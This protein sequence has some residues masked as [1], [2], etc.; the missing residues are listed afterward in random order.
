MPRPHQEYLDLIYIIN[1]LL[2]SLGM[3]RYALLHLMRSLT[4]Y[5]CIQIVL[6]CRPAPR[7]SMCLAYTTYILSA[8][9]IK[10]YT[11]INI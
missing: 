7:R 11:Y 8:Y 1:T 10:I 3:I 6:Y 5:L 2:G 9:I 4:L